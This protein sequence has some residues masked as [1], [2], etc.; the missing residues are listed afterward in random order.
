MKP[1]IKMLTD[2]ADAPEVLALKRLL[3]L[4]DAYAVVGRLHA[5][6]SWWDEKARNGVVDGAVT[7]TCDEV[8]HTPGFGAA[9]VKV[10]WLG[11]DERGLYMPNHDRHNGRAAKDRSL[12]NQRQEVYR[13][14]NAKGD[15]KVTGTSR[16]SNAKGVTRLDKSSSNKHLPVA[17]S[18]A[19]P[20]STSTAIEEPQPPRPLDQRATPPT[21]ESPSEFYR[22]HTKPDP[23][24][25]SEQREGSGT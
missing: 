10:K 14:R 7:V 12:A 6:W 24:A 21:G 4:P 8:V 17:K 1:W 3:E 23:F 22:R 15:A 25:D 2:L 11:E 16:Q 18:S 20:R 9:M 13:A 19:A 5:F